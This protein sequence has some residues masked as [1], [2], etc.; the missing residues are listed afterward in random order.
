MSLTLSQPNPR[1][2]NAGPFKPGRRSF[3]QRGLV[4]GTLAALVL[5]GMMGTAAQAR[6]FIGFGLGVPFYYPYAYPPP[7]YYPPYYA[8]P[9]AVY[10]P[11]GGY[12]PPDGQ[13]SYT[14]P[15][16]GQS[17]APP[18]GYAPG[19]YAQSCQAGSYVCPL[20]QDTPPG[21]QCSCPGN[22]GRRIRGQAN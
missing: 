5:C 12:A 2:L 14:P 21:G 15:A 11:P 16:G 8:P 4:C 6:V 9:P 17:L 3:W 18:S 10:A 19:A 1:P 22:N 13:F 20:V 7:A